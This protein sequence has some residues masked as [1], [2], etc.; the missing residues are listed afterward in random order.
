MLVDSKMKINDSRNRLAGS[1]EKINEQE[2]KRQFSTYDSFSIKP[3]TTR[4]SRCNYNGTEELRKKVCCTC[5]VF[6]VAN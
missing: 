5:K 2:F 6:F 4:I 1:T 3:V